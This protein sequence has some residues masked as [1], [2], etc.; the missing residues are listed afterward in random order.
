MSNSFGALL[1]VIFLAV[2]SAACA[3]SGSTS[4][5]ST[6][7]E[8]SYC[9]TSTTYP[10]SVSITGTAVYQRREFLASCLTG[11]TC[12]LGSPGSDRAIR[13]AEVRIL[14]GTNIIQCGQTDSNG[15]FS[16][17]V[18]KDGTYTV[19]VNARGDNSF[20]RASVLKSPNNRSLFSLSSGALT[21]SSNTNVGT[22][23]A[24]A[25]GDLLGGAFNIFEQIVRANEYLRLKVSSSEGC[26]SPGCTPF[27]V[28][29]KATVYW[30]PGVNPGD[31]FGSSSLVSFYIPSQ[32]GLY[33]LGGAD[34]ETDDVDTDHFDDTVIL[35]EYGHFLEDQFSK[36]DSPGGSHN[37][38]S[39]ID[40]RLAWS[41]GFANFFGVLV[42]AHFNSGDLRYRDSYGNSNSAVRGVLFNYNVETNSPA[43]DVA[44]TSGEG[45]F[46]EFAIARALWDATDRSADGNDSDSDGVA[47]SGFV[48]EFWTVFSGSF[49]SP[50][51]AFRNFGLFFELFNAAGF[52]DTASLLSSSG[53]LLRA[54]R[55]DY[56][57]PDNGD[58]CT[59]TS[60]A[61]GAL[62]RD[63]ADSPSSFVYNQFQSVDFYHY[64]HPGGQA[65]ISLTRMTGNQDLDLYVYPPDHVF[66]GSSLGSSNSV[67]GSEA[68][69]VNGTAANW[70]IAVISASGSTPSHY[71]LTITND[72]V[73]NNK[74]CP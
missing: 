30:S 39:I 26:S 15:Q 1:G 38:N 9:S 35:H 3:P 18:P 40:P 70:M 52:T 25:T 58:G 51:R 33:I 14:Q 29:P 5:G 69:S 16:L 46:R 48:R 10:D 17:Q 13:Y 37:G 74:V 45:N 44:T 32:D 43:R 47:A 31:Y 42:N 71:N 57:S 36:T 56:A 34:G 12:Y 55:L 7:P 6:A 8:E 67:G 4:S 19:Q 28:A 60:S 2:L 66:G 20:V 41:E 11:G 27:T 24:N 22:L 73:T 53:Q 62:L 21:V 68:V 61:A 23:R 63:S 65:S 49:A 64:S 72:S 59:Y 54:S 50:S